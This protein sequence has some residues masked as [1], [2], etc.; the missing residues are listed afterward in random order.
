MMG[1]ILV[2]TL[3]GCGKPKYKLNFDGGFFESEKTEY[4][5]GEKVTVR[6]DIIATDTDYTFWIDDDVEMK[7]DFDGGY[8]F[9]FKM[10]A[11]DVTIHE[12]SRNTMDY[13]PAN[14]IWSYAEK[15]VKIEYER[16][17]EYSD[18]GET[19]DPIL[20]DDIIFQISMLSVGGETDKA[21][22]DFTDI[23]TLTLE[24][25]QSIRIVFEGDVWVEDKDDRYEVYGLDDLRLT[26]DEL[27]E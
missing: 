25:G 4:A 23:L 12:S 11:H 8:V 22:D 21:V 17:W 19:E 18:H 26:L 13:M 15:P 10:P 5:E 3:F 2:F 9:T 7:E 16:M 6:Y 1:V 27:L 24:N 20:I 14:E